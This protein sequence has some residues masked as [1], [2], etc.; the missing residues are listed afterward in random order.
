MSPKVDATLAKKAED[1]L[2]NDVTIIPLWFSVWECA[3]S[4]RV[5]DSYIGTR[6]ANT[7][8]EPAYAWLSK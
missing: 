2:Y 3:V 5:Q 7:W 4:N 1:A 8:W 6:G